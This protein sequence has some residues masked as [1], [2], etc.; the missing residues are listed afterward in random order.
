MITEPEMA[1]AETVETPKYFNIADAAAYLKSIGIDAATPWYV[2]SLIRRGKLPR[3][4]AGRKFYVSKTALN[5]L[6]A[7]NELRVR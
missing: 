6:L 5:G 7:K 3:T 2:A 1:N 4:R